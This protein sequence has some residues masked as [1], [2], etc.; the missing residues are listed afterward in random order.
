MEFIDGATLRE[1]IHRERTELK[2]L[3]KFLQQVAEGYRRLTLESSI[4]ISDNIMITRDGFA[5]LPEFGLA[6][7][8]EKRPEDSATRGRGEE[9]ETLIAPS[10]RRLLRQKVMN[11]KIDQFAVRS[12]SG[13]RSQSYDR[14]KAFT[15]SSHGEARR[16]G[17]DSD[18][19]VNRR[20]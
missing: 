13:V 9:D 3:L 19:T 8:A 20:V 11:D 15:L 14:S 7:L 10:P 12:W 16:D 18:R 5:K 17:R 1:K 2:K 4:A 6:K